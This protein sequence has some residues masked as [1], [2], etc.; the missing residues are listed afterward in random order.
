MIVCVCACACACM[1]SVVAI[2][3]L[4]FIQHMHIYTVVWLKSN[5]MTLLYK[6][7]DLKTK[8]NDSDWNAKRIGKL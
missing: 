7:S 8:K 5:I 4:V 3:D 6:T 2:F 1:F